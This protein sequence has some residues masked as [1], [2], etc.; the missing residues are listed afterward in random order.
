M[1][2]LEAV[3]G[4]YIV[5]ISKTKCGYVHKKEINVDNLSKVVYTIQTNWKNK[6]FLILPLDL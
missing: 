5:Y 2:E 6:L 1:F 4:G 3:F